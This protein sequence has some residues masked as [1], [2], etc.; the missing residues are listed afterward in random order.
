[1]SCN[2]V[3]H[4]AERTEL[5]NR[6]AH[7]VV[8]NPRSMLA[9]AAGSIIFTSPDG[10]GNVCPANS[11]VLH[12]MAELPE[13]P[14]ARMRLRALAAIGARALAS[15]CLHHACINAT[16]GLDQPQLRPLVKNGLQ[17]LVLPRRLPSHCAVCGAQ[18][19]LRQMIPCDE[20][21]NPIQPQLSVDG[22][23]VLKKLT[24]IYVT[25]HDLGHVPDSTAAVTRQ[26]AQCRQLLRLSLRGNPLA[27]DVFQLRHQA[28]VHLGLSFCPGIG[29]NSTT[30]LG[31][32]PSLTSLQ[33]GCE[34]P[35]LEPQPLIGWHDP[36][37]DAPVP[38]HAQA[39]PLCAALPQ[40]PQLREL[41]ISHNTHA[42]Q[43]RDALCGPT[44][45]AVPVL[46]QLGALTCLR[47]QGSRHA[48]DASAEQLVLH[49]LPW[50]RN[51]QCFDVSG[52][53]TPSAGPHHNDAAEDEQPDIA[54]QADQFLAL[55]AL[56]P[57]TELR[58]QGRRLGTRLADALLQA[59]APTLVCLGVSVLDT[60]EASRA[61]LG[62]EQRTPVL[63]EV[64]LA[65]SVLP[66]DAA[67]L[68]DMWN[69]IEQ[70]LQND[71]DMR[72]MPEPGEAGAE[73]EPIPAEQNQ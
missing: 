63:S 62:S 67:Q 57:L 49:V 44:P 16:T 37:N 29:P 11:V 1:M 54:H 6:I 45:A 8:H 10:S 39:Q 15:A 27:G 38:A 28:L 70:R 9:Q 71:I 20:Y 47:F 19:P 18:Q 4:N 64:V 40:M 68:H 52:R 22:R 12:A 48:H 34:A 33:L 23:A 32:C 46:R 24:H 13:R 30:S 59:V 25:G 61:L 7:A 17:A 50:L 56:G 43:E 26:L 42:H 14:D 31:S 58:L 53:N 65:T 66:Q 36:A 60:T 73:V 51:L 69:D 5:A 21:G 41:N 72:H 3:Q 2:S 55:Q 35:A